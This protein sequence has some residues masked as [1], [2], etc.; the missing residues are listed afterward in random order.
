MKKGPQIWIKAV[1]LGKEEYIAWAMHHL[2]STL[3]YF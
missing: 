1:L 2:F 3:P